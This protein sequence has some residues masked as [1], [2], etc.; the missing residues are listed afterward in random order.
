MCVIFFALQNLLC[1]II[2][3]QQNAAVQGGVYLV[4]LWDTFAAGTSLLFTVL[5]LCVTVS[6]VYGK[7][8]DFF[9]VFY[10]IL[11]FLSYYYDDCY[12]YMLR[13]CL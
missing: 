9:S 6:W 10:F 5:C 2:T 1:V 8:P 7:L 4:T 13:Y 11:I 12:H 3:K